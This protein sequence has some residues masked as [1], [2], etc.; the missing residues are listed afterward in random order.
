MQVP[1]PVPSTTRLKN[2]RWTVL[3][4]RPAVDIDIVD[5]GVC[6]AGV[7]RSS[8]LAC[9]RS[10]LADYVAAKH[11]QTSQLQLMHASR[12]SLSKCVCVLH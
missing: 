11:E 12:G 10:D 1:V 5:I 2:S 8:L 6:Q 9:G 4:D 3:A 7:L